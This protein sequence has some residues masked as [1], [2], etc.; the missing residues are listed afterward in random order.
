MS[1]W[2]RHRARLLCS[3]FLMA[4]AGSAGAQPAAS[5][6]NKPVRVIVPFAIGSATTPL[7]TIFND[8]FSRDLGQNFIADH[9]P[10]GDTIIGTTVVAKAAPDGYTLLVTS[11][12]LLFNHWTRQDLSYNGLKDL[13]PISSLTRSQSALAINPSVPAHDLKEFISYAKANPGK[14][15][16]VSTAPVAFL[17]YQRLMNATGTKFTIVNYKGGS[18]VMTDLLAGSVQG[19]ITNVSSLESFIKSGKLRGIA[20]GGDKRSPALPDLP[21][22]AEAGVKDYDP[23]NWITLFAPSKTPR[24]IIEKLNA[25]VRK[26]QTAP[27]V[28][29]ALAKLNLQ[30]NLTTVAQAQEFIRT[31]ADRF[32]KAIKDSGLKAGDF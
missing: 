16:L 2:T 10:G 5:Y 1:T 4:V 14:L 17:H 6:P 8:K 28:I 24:D 30:P 3:G 13:T 23:G 21:T 11:S 26:A 15:N 12:S 31:E 22:F 29:S 9:R 32:G 25:Q 18:Q 27:E 7:L 19:F 20:I